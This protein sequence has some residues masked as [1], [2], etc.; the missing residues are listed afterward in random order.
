VGVGLGVGATSAAVASWVTA[1]AA[2]VGAGLSYQSSDYARRQAAQD[3]Q[4]QVNAETAANRGLALEEEKNLYDKSQ[5]ALTARQRAIRGQAL[6]F[7]SN[8]SATLGLNTPLASK[9]GT[10]TQTGAVK[11]GY[12]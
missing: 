8:K 1:G 10:T 4:D 11:L 2:V 5:A 3:K 7:K 9:L 12:A 6:T